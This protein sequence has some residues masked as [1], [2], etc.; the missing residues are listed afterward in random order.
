MDRCG[1]EMCKLFIFNVLF[2]CLVVVSVC[3]QRL[4]GSYERQSDWSFRGNRGN[5]GFDVGFKRK[6]DG[7]FVFPNTNN[8]HNNQLEFNES[9]GKQDLK[10]EGTNW[11]GK[12]KNKWNEVTK[13]NYRKSDKSEYELVS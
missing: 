13:G 10:A 8:N 11:A 2:P 6:V 1:P 12:V 4:F 7:D 9:E 3:S 5:S